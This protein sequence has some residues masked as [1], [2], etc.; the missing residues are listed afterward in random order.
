MYLPIYIYTYNTHIITCIVRTCLTYILLRCALAYNGRRRRRCVICILLYDKS[1]DDTHSHCMHI[2]RRRRRWL[3]AAVT[4][5]PSL[6]DNSRVNLS[7]RR[8]SCRD[9]ILYYIIYTL[10]CVYC[11]PRADSRTHAI[12]RTQNAMPPR[13][14]VVPPENRGGD[15]PPDEGR[16]ATGQV[17]S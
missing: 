3:R 17:P 6:T 16:G 10:S 5:R 14:I 15:V 8:R 4:S 12:K 11:L 2:R 9:V 13:T 1:P 7:K